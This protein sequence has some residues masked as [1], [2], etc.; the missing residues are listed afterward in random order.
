MREK[1]SGRGSADRLDGDRGDVKYPTDT[2]LA[3]AGGS[4]LA[5]ERRKPERLVDKNKRRA[6]SLAV[7]GPQATGR[8]AGRS[9]AA[10]GR[11]RRRCSS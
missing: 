4:T 11:P 1:R 9:V 3:S 5:L 8:S 2:E 10:L 6:G 7:D